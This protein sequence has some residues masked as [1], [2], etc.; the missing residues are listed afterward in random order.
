MVNAASLEPSPTSFAHTLG[1]TSTT[2]VVIWIRSILAINMGE[3]PVK[4]VA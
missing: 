1:R 2:E 3:W 4:S